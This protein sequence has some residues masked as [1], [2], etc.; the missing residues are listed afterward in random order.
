[1]KLHYFNSIKVRLK[2]AKAAGVS[3]GQLFQF[4]KGTIKT[5]ILFRQVNQKTYFN[6]IKVRLKLR[7]RRAKICGGKFQ[8]HKGTIKTSVVSSDISSSDI[9]IP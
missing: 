4:H 1:M 2:L 9:S 8:F 5:T 6:S 3:V 7:K